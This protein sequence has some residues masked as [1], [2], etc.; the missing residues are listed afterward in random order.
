M[1]GKRLKRSFT[2][3]LI[4]TV[5]A[6]LITGCGSSNNNNN[7]GATNTNEPAKNTAANEANTG[8]NAAAEA[9]PAPDLSPIEFTINTADDK[10][11]WD[12]PITKAITEKTGVSLKYDLS[13]GDQFQKWDL[14]LAAGDYPDVVVLDANYTQ[15]FK[16]A[17]AIIPLND[18]IDKYGPN[19]KEKYGK[20]FNL[21]KDKDGNI[22]SLSGVNKSEEAAANSTANFIVQYDVLKE[23]GYPEIK[24]FDQL[25]DVIKAY[26]DKHP[27]I[28]G[29]DTIGFAASM[30]S[31]TMKI[32]FNNPVINALGLPDHDRSRIDAN[33]NVTYN[34]VS[35]E[36]KAY[37]KFLNKLYNNGLF[38][39][40]AFSLDNIATKAAQGRVLAAYSPGWFLGDAE[41]SLRN[42][43]HP[44]RA[45][46]HIPIYFSEGTEDHSNT[47]TPTQAGSYQW[48]ISKNAK[49]P[50]RMI[51]MIDFLFSDEGQILT[52]WG[53][54]GTHFDVKDGHRV[55]KPELIQQRLA[56]PDTDYKEGFHGIGTGNFS[57]FGIGNGAK[58]ADGDYSTPLTKDMVIANYDDMTKEVLAKYGKQVWAD[59]LPPVEYVP[60]YIWQLTPPES[61]KVEEQKI[62]DT[63]RKYLPKVI[64][65]KDDA[66]FD[67]NW[68]DMQDAINKNGLEKV[69]AAYTQ[70]W[71]DFNEKY[72]SIL[73]Q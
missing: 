70:L 8:N 43:G 1:K 44:E 6:V 60:G 9:E 72:N 15:K 66:A 47:L 19:I 46:A 11:K 63:W 17:G 23:A 37:L 25:Y 57:W 21:L 16:D 38:D 56:D 64:M 41:A 48:T 42:S 55:L 3:G 22:Y 71:A 73:G 20:Y 29:K 28:D 67:S 53:I 58:L 33:G 62:D 65:S 13:V 51:Q 35:E 10:L 50:E 12:T 4:I 69:E 26:A 36:S 14:W 68:K 27:Q 49:N 32:E 24:T 31:W 45:Y 61:T 2:F 54:E 5:L 7:E 34:P 59:F 52:Q 39:K 40:E 18:L 30:A